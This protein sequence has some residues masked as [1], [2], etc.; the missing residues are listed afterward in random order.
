MLTFKIEGGCHRS[1]PQEPG[2]TWVRPEVLTV[3]CV[4]RSAKSS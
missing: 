4:G 1:S 2:K 3:P